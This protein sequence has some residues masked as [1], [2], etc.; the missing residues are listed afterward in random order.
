MDFRGGCE[1]EVSRQHHSGQN[2]AIA[3]ETRG[4]STSVHSDEQGYSSGSMEVQEDC[5]TTE[6][7]PAAVAYWAERRLGDH[8]MLNSANSTGHIRRTESTYEDERTV[9]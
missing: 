1:K 8:E 6:R 7:I 5:D 4:R 3:V 2:S 9:V